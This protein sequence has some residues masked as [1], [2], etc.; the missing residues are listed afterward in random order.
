MESIG[1]KPGVP[2]V[3][4]AGLSE[5]IGGLLFASGLFLPV[6]AFLIIATML[7]AVFKVHSSNGLWIT[8]NGYEYNLVLI[9]AVLG[10]VLIGPGDYTLLS[11]F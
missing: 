8:N 2:A 5:M 4:V 9:A 10:V 1:I 3:I 11:L 6:A 7:V